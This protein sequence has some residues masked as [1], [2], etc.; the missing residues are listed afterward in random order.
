MSSTS[1]DFSTKLHTHEY[2]PPFEPSTKWEVVGSV[3]GLA[4]GASAGITVAAEIKTGKQITP[5]DLHI[6]WLQGQS[7]GIGQT[8]QQLHAHVASD[9]QRLRTWVG[10]NVQKNRDKT[11][12][13]QFNQIPP[14]G[15]VV[16]EI[17]MGIVGSLVGAAAVAGAVHFARQA[18]YAWKKYRI[19]HFNSGVSDQDLRTHFNLKTSSKS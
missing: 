13:L 6:S 18:K 12:A 19:Q 1:P 15:P 11:N 17:G 5:T 10:D 2:V 3:A 14:N 8:W 16:A 7:N 9:R 4:I